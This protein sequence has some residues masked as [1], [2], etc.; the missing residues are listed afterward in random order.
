MAQARYRQC[1]S[2]VT[3]ARIS[4]AGGAPIQTTRHPGCSVPE[5]LG[6]GDRAYHRIERPKRWSMTA[7]VHTPVTKIEP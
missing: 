5:C 1:Y 6:L 7:W 2:P 4:L 3:A